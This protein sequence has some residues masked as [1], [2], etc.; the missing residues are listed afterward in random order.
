MRRY[1]HTKEGTHVADKI[2]GEIKSGVEIYIRG[3]LRGF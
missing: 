3:M 2:E 1:T